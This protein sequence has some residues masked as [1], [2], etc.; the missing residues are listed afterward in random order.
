MRELSRLT[1]AEVWGARRLFAS[2]GAVARGAPDIHSVGFA[3]DFAGFLPILRVK[4][5]VWQETGG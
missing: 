3:V 5:L 4:F 2:A 1:S